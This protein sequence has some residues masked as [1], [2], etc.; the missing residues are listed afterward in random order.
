MGSTLDEGLADE[1]SDD[2]GDDALGVVAG[3]ASAHAAKIKATMA[4]P[5]VAV[6]RWCTTPLLQAF[7]AAAA[8]AGVLQ[9][10]CA[11]GGP[12]YGWETTEVYVSRVDSLVLVAAGMGYFNAEVIR[13][14]ALAM[15]DR[16]SRLGERNN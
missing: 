14:L 4:S 6:G 3:P 1:S 12:A 13:S 8:S 2:A 7:S 10:L 11:V 9:S 15:N 5:E 16:A